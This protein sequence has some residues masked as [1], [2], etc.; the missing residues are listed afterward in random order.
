MVGLTRGPHRVDAGGFLS[1]RLTG[2]RRGSAAGLRVRFLRVYMGRLR[3]PGCEALPPHTALF[4][5][6]WG[7]RIRRP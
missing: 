7:E 4:G 1:L 2:M 3:E 5:S 6:T